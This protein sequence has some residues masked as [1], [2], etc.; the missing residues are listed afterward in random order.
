MRLIS[1]VETRFDSTALMLQRFLDLQ[2]VIQDIVVK[3]NLPII[4]NNNWKIIEY[5]VDIGSGST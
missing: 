3:L 4:S 2:E 1:D 5:I